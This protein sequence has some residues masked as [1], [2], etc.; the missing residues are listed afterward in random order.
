MLILNVTDLNIFLFKFPNAEK[1]Y[2]ELNDKKYN[3]RI[4]NEL[5]NEKITP[6][7]YRED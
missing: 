5:E 6:D 7:E 3:E 1:K 2:D 4:L